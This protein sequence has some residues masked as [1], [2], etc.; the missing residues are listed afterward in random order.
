MSASRYR[1]FLQLCEKWPVDK[2]R[3]ERNLGSLL[4]KRIME[5]FSKAEASVV[6]EI[7]CDRAYTSLQRIV[8]DVHRNKWIRTQ[9][10]NA[11]GAS[12]ESLHQ[13]LS[14][15]G[16]KE[17]KE[18]GSKGLTTIYKEKAMSVTSSFTSGKKKD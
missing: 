18:E 6:D 10:T 4:R 17:I 7:T 2:S 14:D 16:L 11:T 15:E 3:G 8:A 5:S 13:T 9:T 1:N 12:A